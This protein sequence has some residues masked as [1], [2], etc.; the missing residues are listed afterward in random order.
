MSFWEVDEVRQ[1]RQ[2][3]CKLS[4]VVTGPATGTTPADLAA[5]F[6]RVTEYDT[7]APADTTLNGHRGKS[8][9]IT[10]PDQLG[11]C[12]LPGR[13]LLWESNA[14]PPRYGL[15]GELDTLWILDVE[16]IR[17][18]VDATSFAQTSAADQTAQQQLVDSIRIERIQTP[19]DPTP[20]ASPSGRTGTWEAI[21]GLTITF[22]L[23]A[24][25]SQPGGTGSSDNYPT[26]HVEGPDPGV[27]VNFYDDVETVFQNP[28]RSLD[29]LSG[30]TGSTPADLAA[31][32]RSASG[33]SATEPVDVTLVGFRGKRLT[34]EIPESLIG[35]DPPGM[36]VSGSAQAPP[37]PASCC[38]SAARRDSGC[39]AS[40]TRFG[41][42]MS[43]ASA[44]SWRPCLFQGP[45]A[46][47]LPPSSS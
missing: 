6:E 47:T 26:P 2:H 43:T 22:D 3:P 5:A 32:L 4:G 14:Q 12:E 10:L 1:V 33:Y 20:P 37:R 34:L 18:V 7:T 13:A 40:E 29:R 19:A 35:C 36:N 27:A 11:D 9:R 15:P 16:G 23:P 30:S 46:K 21:D 45:P 8:L 38:G 31:K 28:C 25:W 17:L 39:R 41:S 44:W 24:G 42:S